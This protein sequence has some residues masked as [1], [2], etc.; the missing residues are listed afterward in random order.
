MLSLLRRFLPMPKAGHHEH[1]Q[2]KVA[3]VSAALSEDGKAGLVE[4]AEERS[5]SLSELL[6][7]IG[8][9][10]IPLGESGKLQASG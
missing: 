1:G 3:R 9:R 7:Q 8:R 5:I 4:L 2:P 6:E 10:Q